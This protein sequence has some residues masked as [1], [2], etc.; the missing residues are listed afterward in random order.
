[1]EREYIKIPERP[2][3]LN[4]APQHLRALDD[5]VW[6]NRIFYHLLRFYDNYDRAELKK[7][8]EQEREEPHPRIERRIARFIRIKLREDKDFSFSFIVSGEATNDEEVEGYYDI[9]INT[10]NWNSDGFCFECKNL[11]NRQDSVNKYIVYNQGHSKY[12]GGV[13]RY[14]NGK[15]AQNVNFGGMIGF[16]IKGEVLNIRDKILKK[17]KEK[18]DITPE[19]DL[20]TIKPNSIAENDFT[21]DSYHK[22]SGSEFVIHHLL[23]NFSQTAQ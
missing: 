16:V 23:F 6:K 13:Y 21:F 15:Y 9:L 14:F 11:D 3:L 2:P 1:M 19:G 18:F 17:L 5:K 7:E 20:L 22:R 4:F 10:P 12:D 8:I